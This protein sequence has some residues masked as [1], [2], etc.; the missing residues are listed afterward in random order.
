MIKS[1]N[2]RSEQ[3]QRPDEQRYFLLRNVPELKSEPH[4]GQRG[5]VLVTPISGKKVPDCFL[6]KLPERRSGAFLHKNTPDDET[7]ETPRIRAT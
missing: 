4:F 5:M 7:F 6:R 1:S 2:G 3:V